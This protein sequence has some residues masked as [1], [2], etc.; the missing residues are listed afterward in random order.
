MNMPGEDRFSPGRSA[1]ADMMKYIE[2]SKQIL[3]AFVELGYMLVLAAV[4][5]F[6]LMGQG[7]GPFITGVADNVMK[8]AN[9][10]QPQALV[11]I[12]IVLALLYLITR[13]VKG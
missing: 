11:G 4:L 3:W 8:F 1:E 9:G 10:M 5:I 7:S 12:A 13:R 2:Q 6:L